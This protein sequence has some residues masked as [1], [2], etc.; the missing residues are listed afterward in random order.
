MM[1]SPGGG[2]S[3]GL[4]DSLLSDLETAWN[5]REEEARQL[6]ALGYNS[7]ALALRLY[8]LEIRLKTM[9]CKQLKLSYLPKACKTHDL[10]ELIIF[11]GLRQELNDPANVAV[12][13]NWDLLVEFSKHASERSTIPSAGQP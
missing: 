11:T 3:A 9:I 4:S 13:Q 1:N 6:I 12:Q 7:T 8:S 10:A 2:R 5:E